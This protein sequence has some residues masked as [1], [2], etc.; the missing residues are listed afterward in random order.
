MLDRRKVV[1]LMLLSLHLLSPVEPNCPSVCNCTSIS[2]SCIN[3]NLEAIPDFDSLLTEPVTI[4]LSGNRI[5]IIDAE[6]FDFNQSANVKEMYLNNTYLI[7]I[8]AGAFSK[9]INLQ[10]LYLGFNLLNYVPSDLI[11][12]LPNMI[13]LD[14]SGNYFEGSMPVL[15]SQS[16]EVFTLLDCMITRIEKKSLI[17]L[18]NLKFLSLMQN[19][20][21]FI[22][23]FK[24][25]PHWFMLKLPYTTWTCDCQTF[26]SFDYLSSLNYIDSSG[27]YECHFQNNAV[28]I[29]NSRDVRTQLCGKTPRGQKEIRVTKEIFKKSL[30]AISVSTFQA[31][32]ED[33]NKLIEK[34]NMSIG[35][36]INSLMKVFFMFVMIVVLTVFI[37]G[38]F[39]SKN[40]KYLRDTDSTTRLV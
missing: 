23:S 36:S 33:D 38:T 10:E 8:D 19:N 39:A 24:S 20:L 15:K 11:R 31:N 4:D 30:P 2:V 26:E 16:L 3:G 18:P 28:Q 1:P 5:S 14:L 40:R 7:D 35:V 12:Y 37:K 25:I 13:L 9:L 34:R 17:H 6:N 21:H 27:R 29:F 32:T 22:D